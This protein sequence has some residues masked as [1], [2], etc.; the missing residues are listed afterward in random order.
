MPAEH[1]QTG[2][3]LRYQN[4]EFTGPVELINK[5][6]YLIFAGF[7]LWLWVTALDSGRE[8]FEKKGYGKITR[9]IFFVKLLGFALFVAFV[10]YCFATGRI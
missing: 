2:A 6:I 5:A 10:V 1:G 8:F 3:T 7:A 4:A 9:S